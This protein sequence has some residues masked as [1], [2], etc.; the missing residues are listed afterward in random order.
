MIEFHLDA[1]SGVAP[2]MQLIRQVRHALR[3]GVLNE[4]DKLPTVKEVVARVAINP[5][6]V[7]KAYRELEYEGLVTARPGLGTFVT[8]TL[9]G[10]SLSKHEPLR[11][12]LARWLTEA[13]EA[14]LDDES[15]EALFLSS[16]RAFSEARG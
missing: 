7:S 13:R 12:G 9:V 4:G 2:Y 14:G 15:I 1:R 10:D 3:L 6:T 5:N 11:Q 16:F 8:R